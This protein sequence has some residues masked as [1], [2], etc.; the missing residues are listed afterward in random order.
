[1][2]YVKN[3]STLFWPKA[4]SMIFFSDGGRRATSLFDHCATYWLVNL[5]LG[6]KVLLTNNNRTDNRQTTVTSPTPNA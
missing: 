3:L 4:T 2:E 1:M 5:Q 6:T